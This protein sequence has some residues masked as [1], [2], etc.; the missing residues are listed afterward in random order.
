MLGPD[1]DPPTDRTIGPEFSA[2][3]ALTGMSVYLADV[4]RSA[5]I[6]GCF[7]HGLIRTII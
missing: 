6:H 5:D 2:T 4:S 1:R 7:G 3:L